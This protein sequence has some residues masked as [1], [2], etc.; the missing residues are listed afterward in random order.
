[1]IFLHYLFVIG[2]FS[3]NGPLVPS[4]MVNTTFKDIHALHG[5]T[6]G[7]VLFINTSSYINL[8]LERCIFLSCQDS[9][10]GGALHLDSSSSFI[11]IIQCRFENSYA[12][13]RG[14]DIYVTDSSCF[15]GNDLITDSCTTS[16]SNASVYC[17]Y[18]SRTLLT[19][20]ED[21]VV[22]LFFLFF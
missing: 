15:F 12:T 18:S 8:T 4:H 20:C 9:N 17:D 11:I 5:N 7:G 14:Y 19:S 3:I 10:Y 6:R 13:Y 22:L 2:I 1:M 16:M 21:K